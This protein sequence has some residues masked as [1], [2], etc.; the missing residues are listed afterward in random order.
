MWEKFN[1]FYTYWVL[2]IQMGIALS[3]LQVCKIKCLQAPSRWR[4][5][6]N[7]FLNWVSY[8]L[9]VSFYLQVIYVVIVFSGIYILPIFL[10]AMPCFLWSNGYKYFSFSL[11]SAFNKTGCAGVMLNGSWQGFSV[12]RHQGVVRMMMNGRFIHCLRSQYSNKDSLL[13][14]L[15]SFWLKCLHIFKRWKLI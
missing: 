15:I 5:L 4:L 1:H 2:L 7:G 11:N 9:S 6:E 14:D 8:V 12:W 3:L 13:L 10:K